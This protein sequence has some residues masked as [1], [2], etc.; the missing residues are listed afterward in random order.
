MRLLLDS[1]AFVWY[2]LND[3]KLDLATR[4]LIQQPNQQVYLS[5]V[6]IWEM[7]IKSNLGKFPLSLPVVEFVLKRCTSYNFELLPLTSEDLSVLEQ[8]PAHHRDP[9]DRLLI[10]QAIHNSL[11]LVTVDAKVRQYPISVLP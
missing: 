5:L 7:V 3:N 10:S 11:T 1:H 4:Q 6:S 9:F 8:L 2:T